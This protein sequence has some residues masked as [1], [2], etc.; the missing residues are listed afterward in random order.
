MSLPDELDTEIKKV[1]RE[2][3]RID[4]E[5]QIHDLGEEI[6]R[7][8]HAISE[9]IKKEMDSAGAQKTSPE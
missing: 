6:N 5:K 1:E 4:L 2:H 7:A 8:G 9:E 3:H